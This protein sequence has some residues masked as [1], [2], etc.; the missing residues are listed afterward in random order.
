MLAT[1]ILLTNGGHVLVDMADYEA[2]SAR[3]WR[4]KSDAWGNT[5]AISREPGGKDLR[6]HRLLAGAEKG[7]IVDHKDGNTLNNCRSNLRICTNAENVRNSKPYRSEAGRRLKGITQRPS[8]KWRAQIM[9]ERKKI[10]LGQFPD[11]ESAARAYDA[12]ATRLFG[13]FA[14][15]NFPEVTR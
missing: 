4:G 15:L 7:Q 10:V 2:V 1:T 8:G 3:T 13:E 14:R 9:F 6:M 11:P 12:A 5:Y